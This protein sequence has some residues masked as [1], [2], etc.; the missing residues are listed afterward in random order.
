M[1]KEALRSVL[2]EQHDYKH[3]QVDGVID[4][5][6]A[7]SPPIAEAFAHWLATGEFVSP[8]I[9]G[10][11]VQK[12]VEKQRMKPVAAFIQLQWLEDEPARALRSLRRGPI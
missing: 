2:V 3:S 4:R 10:Y 6:E 12:I 8:E 9:A 1:N 7:F 5:I 11:T